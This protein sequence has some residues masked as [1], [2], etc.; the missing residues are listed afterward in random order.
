MA[1][2]FKH[3]FILSMSI[4]SDSF[5]YIEKGKEISSSEMSLIHLSSFADPKEQCDTIG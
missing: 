2:D 4:S 1:H 3:L 5:N